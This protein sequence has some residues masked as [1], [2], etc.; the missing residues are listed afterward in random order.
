MTYAEIRLKSNSA[1]YT[2]SVPS[3]L[4]VNVGDTVAVNCDPHKRGDGH[5]MFGRV[6]SLIDYPR[7]IE[8][9]KVKPIV[10]KIDVERWAK[11]LEKENQRIQLIAQMEARAREIDFL[12]RYRQIAKGD[13]EMRVLMETFESLAS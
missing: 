5:L 9:S 13:E 6:E 1:L 4:E 11:H 10:D 3:Y 2:Y 12:E 8:P 7:S